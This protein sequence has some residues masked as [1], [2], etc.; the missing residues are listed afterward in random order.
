MK[1]VSPAGR[2]SFDVASLR[3]QPQRGEVRPAQGKR[4]PGA[5]PWVGN[6]AK[7][8][9]LKGRMTS[10]TTSHAP[11]QGYNSNLLPLPRAVPWAGVTAPLR[12]C[13]RNSATSK[14][15]RRISFVNRPIQMIADQP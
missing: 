11:L 15:A 4:P 2:A 13:H 12:D 6:V 5:S 10:Q 1:P 3:F 9:A 8:Q 14:L 7:P